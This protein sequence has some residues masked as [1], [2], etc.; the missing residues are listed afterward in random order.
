[1]GCALRQRGEA[2]QPKAAI[3][4][5]PDRTN[6]RQ[7]EIR[8]HEEHDPPAPV[9]AISSGLFLTNVPDLDTI[10]S[11]IAGRLS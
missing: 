9:P 6:P 2:R 5:S 3:A 11:E 10:A 4:Q 1:M 7:N 8:T